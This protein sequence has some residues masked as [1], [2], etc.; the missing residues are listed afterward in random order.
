MITIEAFVLLHLLIIHLLVNI[1]KL[2]YL[3][4]KR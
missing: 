3:M 2:D 4:C 1:Y